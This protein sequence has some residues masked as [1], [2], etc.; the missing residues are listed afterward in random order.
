MS[1]SRKSGTPELSSDWLGRGIERD[2]TLARQRLMSSSRLRSTNSCSMS[3]ILSSSGCHAIL[4]PAVPFRTD[5]GGALPSDEWL[6]V[7]DDAEEGAMD[8][9]LA[10]VLDE[11]QPAEL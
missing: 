10:V 8:D 7:Q 11:S 5:P 1:W 4:S 9:Q 6:I 3:P 2:A